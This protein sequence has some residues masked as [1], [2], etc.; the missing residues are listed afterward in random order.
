MTGPGGGTPRR[1]T[2]RGV[3]LTNLS[4]PAREGIKGSQNRQKLPELSQNTPVDGY[5]EK[6]EGRER[7]RKKEK[8]PVVIL[9]TKTKYSGNDG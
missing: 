8:D 1:R 9:E 5:F 6:K 7:K 3:P 4:S 2:E